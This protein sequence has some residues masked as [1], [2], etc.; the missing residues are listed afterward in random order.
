MKTT[1]ESSP[2]DQAP[3]LGLTVHIA[4]STVTGPSMMPMS[5]PSPVPSLRHQPAR[6]VFRLCC[7][8]AVTSSWG[9]S[10][11]NVTIWEC[12]STG[13]RFR[14]LSA[15]PS[16]IADYYTSDYHETMTGGADDTPRSRAYRKENRIRIA[17]LKRHLHSG[18]VLD[19]GCSRGDFAHALGQAGFEAHGLDIAPSACEQAGKLL[20]ADR[21]Y[22][23]SL[24]A[25]APQLRQ[26]FNAV[27]MM[28]VIE[29]CQDVVG[30]L[31]AAHQVLLPNGVLFLRTPTLSSPF[32][33]LATW[34]YK[35][36]LGTYKTALF[37]LYHAEHLYFFNEG[38]IRQ[39]LDECGFD[40]LELT[41]DPLCW[42]N[43][44]TAEL[45]Q[46]PLGNLVLAAT[47]FVGRAL[48]R[49]HGIKVMAR[50]RSSNS[51]TTGLT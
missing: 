23:N 37:K 31:N 43:F 22:C 39:L 19:V 7:E 14:E 24:V 21:V 49:G 40:T 51:D 1:H 3:I 50:R 2:H 28:D 18:K 10:T 13:I 38:G 30:L 35:A 32:H 41:A 48:G 4:K 45:R 5:P 17:D 33:W 42:D 6:C 26:H 11:E 27:T 9:V 36:S 29:H 25:V 47:Y 15:P 34:S 16:T 8:R 12:P 46:G 44:R 20:G